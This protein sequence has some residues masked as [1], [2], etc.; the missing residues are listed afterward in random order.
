[1]LKVC[2]CVWGEE[3]LN[4]DPISP[5]WVESYSYNNFRGFSGTSSCMFVYV[6]AHVLCHWLI[7]MG[8][9]WT[10]SATE[11]WN[12]RIYC[13][14]RRTTFGLQISAWP[15]CRSEIAC[16]KQVVGEPSSKPSLAGLWCWERWEEVSHMAPCIGWFTHYCVNTSVFNVVDM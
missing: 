9:I 3:I 14:M 1:M 12:L 16:W 10:P 6:H 4:T 2:V 11:T 8:F 15:P 13:W 5:H 7:S